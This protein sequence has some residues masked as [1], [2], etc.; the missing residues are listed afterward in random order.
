[1]KQQIFSISDVK[2]VSEPLGKYVYGHQLH[3]SYRRLI[4]EV[5]SIVLT[6][7]GALNVTIIGEDRCGRQSLEHT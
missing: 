7:Q 5:N 2:Q 3:C 6:I 4:C 1:M